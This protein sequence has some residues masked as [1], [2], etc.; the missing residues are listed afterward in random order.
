MV[1]LKAGRMQN[2]FAPAETL[3]THS[4]ANCNESRKVGAELEFLIAHNQ[5]YCLDALFNL[6]VIAVSCCVGGRDLEGVKL[7]E[8]KRS[9]WAA[10]DQSSDEC[11]DE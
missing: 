5:R 1:A 3:S 8:V 2:L 4:N 7:A 11:G 6:R 10:Q 9:R